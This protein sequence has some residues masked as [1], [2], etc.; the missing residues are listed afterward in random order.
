MTPRVK[1]PWSLA[2]ALM[3]IALVVTACQSQPAGTTASQSPAGDQADPNGE[4]ITNMGAEPDTI[5][6]QKESFVQEI[7]VTMKV[8]EA[9]MTPSLKDGKPIPAAAKDQPKVS[10]DGTQYTYTLRDNLK[11][12]DGS[13]VTPADFKYGWE[14]LC[15]PATAGDYAFTGYIVKGCEKWNEMD[16]KKAS[17]ADLDAARTA[18]LDNITT[19]NNTITFNLTEPAPYFNSIAAIWVGVPVKKADVEKGGDK[20]TEPATFIG[21]GPFKLTEWKHNEKMVFERNDSFV[22]HDGQKAK[23]KKWTQVMINEGAV[24]FAAYRNNELDIYPVAAEDLRAVN[25]DA[26]LSKQVVDGPGSCTFYIGFNNKKAPFTDKNVRIAFAKSFDRDQWVKDI[27]GGIGKPATSFI[28]PG[29]PGYDAGDTF[30][31]FDPAAAKAALAKASPEATA[32]IAN[33]KVTYSSSARN[34]TRLEWFQQQWKNNLGVNVALDPVDATTYTQ[35]V[36]KPETLPTMFLLGWCSDYYDQQD[37]LTTVFSSKASSARVGYDSKQF[38]DLV[39]AGDKELNVE[40]RDQ[41]YKQASELLSQDAPAAFI[42]YDATK[43]LEKPWVKNYSITSLG[44]EEAHFTDVYVT[45][46][47]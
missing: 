8:F 28:P 22:G 37:W 43:L 10:P 19:T 17:K 41:D 45:K 39:F 31:K 1:A 23:L 6:P 12:S 9:L 46:K 20:W 21:N 40:K 4:L 2:V 42:Y 38:D 27:L 24:A 16:P 33:L 25:G 13:P 14:R 5:D 11:F 44:F 36:K 47:P 26:T 35:L 7:G 30:Q 3:A 34:K 15:D 18:F 32:A 29:I